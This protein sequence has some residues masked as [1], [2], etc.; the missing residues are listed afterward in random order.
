VIDNEPGDEQ[1]KTRYHIV[2]PN[3]GKSVVIGEILLR[4]NNVLQ[5]RCHMA[6][7]VNQ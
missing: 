1:K 5:R 4:L 2:T 3:H 7:V 6:T